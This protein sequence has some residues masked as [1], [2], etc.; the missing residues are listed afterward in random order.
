MLPRRGGMT[1]RRSLVATISALCRRKLRPRGRCTR[2][3]TPLSA[4]ALGLAAVRRNAP[5][6]GLILRWPR[7]SLTTRPYGGAR[8]GPRSGARQALPHGRAMENGPSLSGDRRRTRRGRG[9]G[10]G[11]V[12]VVIVPVASFVRG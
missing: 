1:L 7:A 2:V 4:S 11:D 3:V 5:R 10:H 9:V 8:R 6:R 12:H